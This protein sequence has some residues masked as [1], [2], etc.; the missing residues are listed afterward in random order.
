MKLYDMLFQARS[1]SKIITTDWTQDLLS[2]MNVLK[3]FSGIVQMHILDMSIQHKLLCKL[4]VT[5][6]AHKWIVITFIVMSFMSFLL[7]IK[8]NIF[9]LNIIYALILNMI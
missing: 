7:F 8:F 3:C 6:F 4:L 2:I 9:I 5:V 1:V